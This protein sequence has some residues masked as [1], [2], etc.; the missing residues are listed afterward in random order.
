MYPLDPFVM[1]GLMLFGAVVGLV[2]SHLV[3]ETR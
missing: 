1:M 3:R 2:V